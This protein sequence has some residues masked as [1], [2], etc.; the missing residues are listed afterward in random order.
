MYLPEALSLKLRWGTQMTVH[1]ILLTAVWAALT[2]PTT[3]AGAQESSSHESPVDKL[4]KDFDADSPG[5]AVGVYRAGEVVFSKGYGLGDLQA[6]AP[7]TSQTVFD[8]ASLSKQFTAFTVAMLAQEGKISLD[9]E[10]QKYVPELPRLRHPITVRH[11]VH[12]TSGLREYGALME[13]GGWQLDEPLSKAEV[14]AILQRQRGLNFIPGERH[15][16]NNTNYL[17]MGLIVE[18]VS[19]DPFKDYIANKIF[20]PLRMASSQVRYPTDPI[21]KRAVNYTGMPD[22][23]FTPN[24]VWDRAYGAGVANVHTSIEDLAKWDRNFF[25]PSVGNEALVKTVYSPTALNS[26]KATTYAYGLDLGTHRGKRA[27]SHGGMG[28]GSFHLL[29]LPDDRLSV[30]VLCNRYSLGAGAPDTWSL[31][32]KIADIFLGAEAGATDIPSSLVREVPVSTAELAK[33]VGLYWKNA[34]PPIRIELKNGQLVEVYDGT[35]YPM[36]P[37]GSGKFRNDEGTATYSF[38]GPEARTLTYHEVPTDFTDVGE[39]RPQWSPTTQE[40]RQAVGR[41]CNDEVP[42]CWSLLLKRNALLLRRPGFA[43]AALSPAYPGTFS[44]VDKNDIGTR[45]MRLILLRSLDGS[46]GRL[47]VFRGRVS[48]VVF[49]RT[50]ASSGKR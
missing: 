23:S 20:K 12:H 5:C 7:I 39:R 49:E 47:S 34:G 1:R 42:V 3:A 44:L 28:G 15:E 31:S 43:D 4:F 6:K 32:R 38:S 46:I 33:Y 19:G 40:L 30:A 22:G 41:Y 11:L 10:V 18:R 2:V 8:V 17:L 21:P 14:L 37:I 36:I 26:G 13:L 24:R 16:Y 45:S 48:D 35:A 25:R 50:A 29:R 9:A 27:I